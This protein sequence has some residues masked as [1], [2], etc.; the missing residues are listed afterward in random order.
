M[1][2]GGCTKRAATLAFGFIGLILAGSI[3]VPPIYLYTTQGGQEADYT[4]LFPMLKYGRH[5]LQQITDDQFQ[6]DPPIISTTSLANTSSMESAKN[7][8][9]DNV[10]ANI[11]PRQAYR[12]LP[13]IN[14]NLRA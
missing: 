7:I 3:I 1:I 4:I 9:N 8:P 5:Y 12:Y 13:I 6:R 10:M 2:L 11:T 14:F